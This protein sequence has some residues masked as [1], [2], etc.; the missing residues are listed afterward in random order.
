MSRVLLLENVKDPWWPYLKYL[1]MRDKAVAGAEPGL[2]KAVEFWSLMRT[3][4]GARA[5]GA[6]MHVL[7][8]VEGLQ[9]NNAGKSTLNCPPLPRSEDIAMVSCPC[10]CCKSKQVIAKIAACKV[11]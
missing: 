8:N 6:L 1:L 7:L 11:A 10:T 5:F 2:A 3:G 4:L 9:L